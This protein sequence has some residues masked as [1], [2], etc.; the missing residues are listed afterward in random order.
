[1]LHVFR[2]SDFPLTT[3]TLPGVILVELATS[4][5]RAALERFE[6]PSHSE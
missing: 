4:P 2:D 1:M 3:R 6:V 5:S